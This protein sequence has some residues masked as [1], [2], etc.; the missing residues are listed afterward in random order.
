MWTPQQNNV[1]V[2]IAIHRHF[3]IVYPRYLS[4]AM[5]EGS[6]HCYV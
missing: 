6:D 5:H 3:S 2:E 1:Y 4:I